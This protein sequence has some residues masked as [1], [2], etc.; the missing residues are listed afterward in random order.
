M[1]L[2]WYETYDENG[3]PSGKTLQFRE[4][5]PVWQKGEWE[6]VPYVRERKVKEKEED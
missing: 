5:I 2:R 1:E 4:E 3:V 6:D